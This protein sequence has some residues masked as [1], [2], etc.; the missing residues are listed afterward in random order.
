[1][2]ATPV[3]VNVGIP[4]IPFSYIGELGFS[5]TFYH[6]APSS[7]NAFYLSSIT[8]ALFG[9]SSTTG[10]F[11]LDFLYAPAGSGCVGRTPLFRCATP[12]SGTCGSSFP[13]P[14]RIPANNDLCVFHTA[15]SADITVVGYLAP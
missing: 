12:A 5:S 4:G 15:N 13:T 3:P 7:V 8:V 11:F 10:P 1:M 2:G 6:A 9:T 14:I